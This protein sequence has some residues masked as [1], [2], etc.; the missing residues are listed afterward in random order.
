M[1]PV[2]A[3]ALSCF[4][5]F[6]FLSATPAFS[7][8]IYVPTD[9]PT[10]QDAIDAAG[11]MDSVRVEPGTYSENIDFGGKPVAVWSLEGPDVTVIDG[12]L[13]GPV[14]T[15]ASGETASALGGFTIRNG[16]AMDGGGVYCSGSSPTITQCVIT[17]NYASSN[18]GGIFCDD[19]DVTIDN[20]TIAGNRAFNGGGVY[21]SVSSP[22]IRH[23]TISGNEA[24]NG[25]GIR[26]FGLKSS[27]PTIVNSILWADE[28]AVG[29]EIYINSPGSEPMTLH[30]SYSDVQGGQGAAYVFSCS[31]DWQSGNI[32]EDPAF[33]APGNWDDGGTPEDPFDDFWVEGDY[34]LSWPSPCLDSGTDAGSTSDIDGDSRPQGGGFDMGSDERACLTIRVP[35]D[36]PTIQ[37]GIDAAAGCDLVLVEPGT[38]EETIDFL[39][40]TII[41]AS[42]LDGD[43]ETE[44]ISP[45]TTVIDGGMAGSVVTFAGGETHETILHGFTLRNGSGTFDG[46]L[47]G[48]G[49]IYC[50]NSSP[51]ILDCM[52]TDNS[53]DYAAGIY[54]EGSEPTI[55]GCAIADNSAADGGGG[56]GLYD[57]SP[58]ILNCTVSANFVESGGGG[59][60]CNL[61]SP[62]LRHC[63]FSGNGAGEGGAIF[64]RNA[65]SPESTSTI[66]WGNT[67]EYGHEIRLDSAPL[68]S[69]LTV[70]FSDVQDG[71]GA[72]HVEPGC[73][74][75]WGAGN[76]D[77]DP[78]F[79]DAPAGDFHLSPGSPCVDSGTHAGVF[80]DMDG[81]PRPLL[82]GYDI[83]ADEFDGPCW[84]LDGD[85]YTDEACGGDDCD[86]S[87]P[88]V[89]PGAEEICDNGIDDDCNGQVDSAE[90]QC[91]VLYVPEDFQTI[92]FAISVATHENT[93]MVYPGTYVE[94]INFD[95]KLIT[96]KSVSGP[97]VTV[98]EGNQAGSVVTFPYFATEEAV[99]DGFTI[100]NGSA[101]EGGGIHCGMDTS[102]TITNC[103][104]VENEASDG[105]GIFCDALSSPTISNCTIS[106][107]NALNK[108][109]GIYIYS[110][111]ADIANCTITNNNALGYG[112]GGIYCE[113]SPSYLTLK[114]CTLSGNSADFSGGALFLETYTEAIATNCI[115]WGN[116]ASQYDEI[117]PYGYNVTIEYSDVQGGWSY[118]PGEGNIDA[119]PLFV[120]AP[121]G[122]Y[123][124]TWGSP[125][126]DTGTDAGV[127]TDMDGDARPLGGGFDMGADE[128]TGEP[129]K[130]AFIRHR[131][132]DNQ[133]LNL[134]N[135]PT[136]VGGDI[137]PLVASDSWIGNVGTNN[138][139]THMT[140]G[141]I[142][143]DGD[144]ELIL[145]RHKLNNDQY[146]NIYD[147]P[148]EVGGDMNPLLA[149]DSWIGEVGTNS[150]ITHLAA[151]DIDGD[152][153]DELIFLRH[154]VNDNQYLTVYDIPTTLGGEIDPLVASDIW[155]GN[156]GTRSEIMLM[157]AGDIDAD[158]IDELI[159][160][161]DRQNTNQYLNIYHAPTEVGGDINPLVASDLWIGNIGT[162]T[163]ITHIAAGD[164]DGDGDDELVF[165]RHRDND[166]Q[167]LNIYHAPTVVE[168]EINPLVA[169]DIWIGNVGTNSEITHLAMIR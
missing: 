66:L 159:F 73:T 69:T 1:K 157:A 118:G 17:G 23:C 114:H 123:H 94:E 166:N 142:D 71:Q 25:G 128:V 15:F 3:V 62:M 88:E 96:V 145:I 19:A 132:N 134:Y 5:L 146:L 67:A 124:L 38:Y 108:G 68:A 136:M 98:I 39:G 34:H 20:C 147:A 2:F 111:Y 143:G 52:I 139:I 40:K 13:A 74:L 100:R 153:T 10:I 105:G 75:S 21:G 12:G 35:M 41:V 7:A 6:L 47:S 4:S 151:G 122:N 127:A 141:D 117:C 59:L 167:Y 24:D 56:I 154:R 33:V 85:G 103:T 148:A 107:N 150:E 64:A 63:T 42:D 129:H 104:I 27:Q 80:A 144:E 16:S 101:V 126:I 161:R 131:V 82:L 125:C 60:Y 160:V 106:G 86:D 93:V 119:D 26:F 49:G 152:G 76:I 155:I 36:Y 149:S 92:Q 164:T 18:G 91:V 162:S 8:I 79:A 37:A 46:K 133:Y 48:G 81:D 110:G 135:A 121:G 158:G 30:V 90:P 28:A 113:T 29:P 9:Q 116:S 70:G 112:G 169:S 65:S 87:A 84:D 89:F 22:A 120:D 54:C 97:D 137:N 53:T 31:L 61:S 165:I 50:V 78:L 45:E 102:P 57:S 156:I 138:E 109:G 44:D 83:G 168:G 43:P 95:G 58:R 11:P 77:A 140:A 130:I 115:F 99:L 51:T 72:A 14:V 32:D 55:D 163:E